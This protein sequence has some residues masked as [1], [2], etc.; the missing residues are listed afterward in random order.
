MYLLE[1]LDQSKLLDIAHLY[2]FIVG[3][4]SKYP[5]LVTTRKIR[6]QRLLRGAIEILSHVENSLTEEWMN[7][8]DGMT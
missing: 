8:P 1:H 5:K 6:C 7:P 3:V 2:D 4:V